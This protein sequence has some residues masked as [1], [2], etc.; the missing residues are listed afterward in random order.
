M[1]QRANFFKAT[2]FFLFP[3]TVRLLKVGEQSKPA[4]GPE[5]RGP[6]IWLIPE[7]ERLFILLGIWLLPASKMDTSSPAQ[8]WSHLD[9]SLSPREAQS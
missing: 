6:T 3:F 7:G 9:S 8:P 1:S 5:E 4:E 2:W